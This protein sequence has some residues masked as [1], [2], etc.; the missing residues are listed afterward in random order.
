MKKILAI[1]LLSVG[2]SIAITNFPAYSECLT[3]SEY[4]RAQQEARDRHSNSNTTGETYKYTGDPKCEAAP[5]DA[6]LIPI[7]L[8]P[9]I[10]STNGDNIYGIRTNVPLFSLAD[11]LRVRF[12]L[13]FKSIDLA[14][15][16]SL[17]SQTSQFN[18]FV[19]AGFGG[20]TLSKF[21]N[22]FPDGSTFESTIFGTTGIDFRLTRD[23][24]ITGAVILPMNSAYGTEFQGGITL[25]SSAFDGF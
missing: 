21:S 10:S 16:Y 1:A 4:N 17:N 15:T 14:L 2:I 11:H 9:S 20:K 5:G 6:I 18:P 7:I 3:P 24:T 23:I 22:G 19:G 25:F 12:G 13:S 8:S